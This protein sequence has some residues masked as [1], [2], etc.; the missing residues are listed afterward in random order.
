MGMGGMMG[1]GRGPPPGQHNQLPSRSVWVGNLH[2]DTQENDLLAEFSM[3]GHIESVKMLLHKNCCFVNFANLDDAIQAHQNSVGKMIRGQPVRIGWGKPDLGPRTPQGLG[4][5][6]T[7]DRFQPCK[8]LWVGNLSEEV[9]DGVLQR[10]FSPY[11]RIEDI[12]MLPQKN[13]AFINLSNVEEALRA[14]EALQGKMVF[15][16]S[17]RINFG[18][19]DSGGGRGPGEPSSPPATFAHPP[20]SQDEKFVIDT[21]AS[22]VKKH[23]RTLEVLISRREHSNP[24]LQFLNPSHASHAYYRWMVH[25]LTN[26][27]NPESPP[28]GF[29]PTPAPFQ[30]QQPFQQHQ[31]F[32]P[33]Q[34]MGHMGQP[35]PG[36]PGAPPP[37]G[38]P[39]TGH[40]PQGHPDNNSLA[41][42][43]A[44]TQF[45][46][47]QSTQ[48]VEMLDALSGT[49]ESIKHGK[50]WILE[51]VHSSPAIAAGF[52]GQLRGLA[53][54]DKKLFVLYL[55]ND[56]LYHSMKTR[57]NQ[58]VVDD[59]FSVAILER[60]P[61]I[62]ASVVDS[63][64]A[65]M[66]G[67]V[68]QILDL[69]VS[70]KIYA[71]EAINVLKTHL[72]ASSIGQKR[73]LNAESEQ[74]HSRQRLH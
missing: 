58:D 16:R 68:E 30:Q 27:L 1:G 66:H 4:P 40:P 50:N 51:N 72:A 29:Q 67:K 28:P 19:D 56:A 3:F 61:E 45:T 41:S 14:R 5:A 35:P 12:K 25:C 46:T 70:R 34:Q 44:G 37:M 31:S 47:T 32:P 65:D 33:Q 64:P 52:V 36:F 43:Q 2:P 8:N 39:P 38:P 24:R 49:K 18:R 6:S 73:G 23:G 69:W 55:I 48:F 54:P 17:M 63:S 22:F 74:A 10:E 59:P 57:Q 62:L 11:G 21:L 53:E 9:T 20:Q 15:G 13:C 26:N 71:P 7:S 60:L 42:L